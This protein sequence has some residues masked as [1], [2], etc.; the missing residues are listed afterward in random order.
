MTQLRYLFVT[1]FLAHCVV[2]LEGCNAQHPVTQSLSSPVAIKQPAMDS[3]HEKLAAQMNSSNAE[4]MKKPGLVGISGGVGIKLL[5]TGTHEVILSFPQRVDGQVPICFCIHSTPRDAAIEYRIQRRDEL[6][7]ALIVTLKADRG[8]EIQLEWAAVVLTAGE[9]IVSE[10]AI[11]DSYRSS[12]KCVQADS[13]IIQKLAKKLWPESG[14][15]DDYAR[16]IQRFIQEMKQ[17]KMPRSLDAI[18]ILDSGMN[19][20]CTANANLALALMR[21]RGIPSR[22]MAVIPPISRRLEM[23]RI[24]EYMNAD[25]RRYFDPSLL[26]ADVP[27]KAWQTVIMAK[28]TIA[29]ENLSMTPR[30]GTAVG[31]PYGQEAELPGAGVMFSGRDF[32]WTMAKPFAEFEPDDEAVLLAVGAWN[33]FL[34]EGVL[35]EGQIRAATAGNSLELTEALKMD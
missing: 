8:K 20:V 16:N 6:N 27:M 14:N 1:S 35:S 29:D 31:C 30:M 5:K 10:D 17:S 33:K 12:T 7:D 25:Q 4:A 9:A 32:F 23:H 11:P 28:S 26:N 3:L 19:T 18:G 15:T 13:Q 22:S 24:V 34:R 2:S 21:A